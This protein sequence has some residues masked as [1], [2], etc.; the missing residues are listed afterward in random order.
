MTEQSL[1]KKTSQGLLW[2]GLSNGLQ[3]LLQ[4]FFGI[5]LA[6]LL[7]PDDYGMVGMLMI[8]HNI[9]SSLKESGFTAALTNKKEATHRDFNAVFW[10]CLLVSIAMYII[11]FFC[12]PLI[13]RF[14]NQPQLTPLARL[15][16]LG[17]LISGTS[18]AHY[19]YLF[20]NMMVKQR[21][22]AQT[23]A[24]L[25]S[26]IVGVVLAFC[27]M[28]Y[29]GIAMQSVTYVVVCTSL[30]WYFS[31]WRPS[32]HIDFTPIKEMI[33]FSVKLLI[34]NI[35]T[36]INNNI[37]SVLLG[38]MFRVADV[39]FYSQAN[40]WTTMGHSLITG[41]IT[42]VAQPVLS[43]VKEDNERQQRIFRKMLRFTAF[44]SFPA[45]LGLALVSNELITIAVTDK[46]AD[47]VPMMQLLCLWGAFMPIQSLYSQSVISK[48][49]SHII[50]WNTIVP[51]LVQIGLLL[52]TARWGIFTM[53]ASYVV[54]NIL[55]MFVWQYF[56]HRYMGVGYFSAIKD[57]A[58]F[59][60]AAIVTM[61]ATYY[62]TLS[63]TNIYLL[64]AAKIVVAVVLYIFIMYVSN[65]QIFR[66]SID[67]IIKKRV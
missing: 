10:F 31:R 4:L 17:F 51:G 38:K 65:A 35:F 57:I 61:V 18:T 12:A 41:M 16:F 23:L 15:L 37:F 33:G 20:K 66:E 58:P 63:I 64:F 43:E 28:A 59:A 40:K 9:A 7:S 47:C 27:G 54:F 36:H 44:I 2:G 45:M 6:R 26:G 62:I 14:Y 8:F 53:I 21:A 67:Y 13:A 1:K 22:I 52:V 25:I 30:F 55:Y 39:G 46:W 29:W 50:M 3:Q 5:F 56:V 60:V 42:G 11:L 49:H 19:A 32:L 48:G 24:I 34:T